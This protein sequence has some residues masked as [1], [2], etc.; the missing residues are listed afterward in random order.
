MSRF[1]K[2]RIEVAFG[3]AADLMAL[4]RHERTAFVDQVVR[5]LGVCASWVYV[6]PQPF[7]RRR[8]A[9]AA[10]AAAYATVSHGKRTN[11]LNHAA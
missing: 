8:R 6:R 4:P 2:I 5:E 10:I 1:S 9:A 3:I 7:R 11:F